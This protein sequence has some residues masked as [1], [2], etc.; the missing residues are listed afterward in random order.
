M[1]PKATPT[2][3]QAGTQHLKPQCLVDPQLAYVEE[4]RSPYFW[5]RN[6]GVFRFLWFGSLCV[7]WFGLLCFLCCGSLCCLWF[8]FP[9]LG[10]LVFSVSG[11]LVSFFLRKRIQTAYSFI[12]PLIPYWIQRLFA[13]V[14]NQTTI[15]NQTTTRKQNTTYHVI[16]DS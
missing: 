8:G 5:M 7:L 15:R 13:S 16:C 10:E 4:G 6:F 3:P 12:F 14:R 11:D 9:C 2:E 1:W